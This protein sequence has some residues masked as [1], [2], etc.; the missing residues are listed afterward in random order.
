M[1][2][3]LV[4]LLKGQVGT[5]LAEKAA[6]FLGE[7][8]GST[9]KAVGAIL[10]TLLGSAAN[11]GST[12]AGAS[13]LLS[14]LNTGGH[15]GGILDNLGSVLGGGSQTDSLMSSGSG[16]LQSLLG[17]KLGGLAGLIANFA[18]IKSGSA[19]SLLS[20]A[21]PLVMGL[22][23]KQVK[24]KG[25]D[26][27]SL[28]HLM[29]GQS[30]FIKAAL[31]S[32][33]VSGLASLGMGNIGSNIAQ[34]AS[35]TRAAATQQVNEASSA[36]FGRF[37]PWLIGAAAIAAALYFYKGCNT[38]PAVETAVPEVTTT[39]DTTTVEAPA[40][41]DKVLTF[42]AGSQE[43]AMLAFIKDASKVVDKTTWFNFPEIQFD[44]N[45][46]TIKAESMDRINNVAAILKAFPNVKVKV[47]GYT[48]KT[49][50][51]ERNLVLSG[52]RAKSV[53]AKLVELGIAADRLDPEGYGSKYAKGT[54][55]EEKAADRKI[56]FRV[57]AK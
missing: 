21:A 3:N 26:A 41:A 34:A 13:S 52:D 36:G 44:V 33:L 16:I 32:G 29:S 47:G 46:A 18:G 53:A 30:D 20:M 9:A 54:T 50:A 12:Q 57:T 17:N 10:P 14:M 7:D 8:S 25:L 49:G 55:E 24:A 11:L 19:S 35:T 39:V 2:L 27:S 37:L 48:D 45:K 51:A 5:M 43:E 23:G 1:S 42:N 38:A 56:S 40:E 15:D 28:M 6:S 31:P 22:L 4:D